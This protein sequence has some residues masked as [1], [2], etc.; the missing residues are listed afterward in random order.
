MDINYFSAIVGVLSLLTALLVGW[1]IY[2]TITIRNRINKIISEEVEKRSVDITNEFN[3]K[4]ADLYLFQ[5]HLCTENHNYS[6]IP[7][8]AGLL[9]EIAT[10][11]NKKEDRDKYC[12]YGIDM[13]NICIEQKVSLDLAKPLIVKALKIL[14]SEYDKAFTILYQIEKPS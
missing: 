5:M 6:P 12:G 11:I 7:L 13:I 9:L 4:M 8:L 2:E 14:S 1:Q 10:S 3:I